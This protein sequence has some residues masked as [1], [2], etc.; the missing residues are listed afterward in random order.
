MAVWLGGWGPGSRRRAMGWELGHQMGK[1]LRKG[2][3]APGTPCGLP[4][5][6]GTQ[7]ATGRKEQNLLGWL[8]RILILSYIYPARMPH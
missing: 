7:G 5:A 1:L 8:K 2:E 6:D 4:L 3:E